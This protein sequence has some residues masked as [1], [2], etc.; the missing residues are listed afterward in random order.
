MQTITKNTKNCV[1][2]NKAF[3]FKDNM[4]NFSNKQNKWK[5]TYPLL[6]VCVYKDIYQV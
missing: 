3:L 6:L 2:F 4:T 5:A 1:T